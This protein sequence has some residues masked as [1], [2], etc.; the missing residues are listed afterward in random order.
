MKLP[1]IGT[2]IVKY[3]ESLN[4]LTVTLIVTEKLLMTVTATERSFYNIRKERSIDTASGKTTN[5]VITV[6]TRHRTQIAFDFYVWET[7]RTIKSYFMNN[8][9]TK[10][11]MNWTLTLAVSE[12]YFCET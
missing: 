11:I 5:R 8:F 7:I 3:L 6:T 4:R 1:L 9:S 10:Q 2:E 12:S